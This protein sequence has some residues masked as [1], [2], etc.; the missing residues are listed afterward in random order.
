MTQKLVLSKTFQKAGARSVC[1][2]HMDPLHLP[3]PLAFAEGSERTVRRL[4]LCD[5]FT[6]SPFLHPHLVSANHSSAAAD[7]DQYERVC[8]CVCD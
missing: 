3:A 8:V 1:D 6:V 5:A 4:T 2:D 7:L